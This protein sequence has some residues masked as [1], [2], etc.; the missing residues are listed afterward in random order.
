MAQKKIT[1]KNKNKKD[2]LDPGNDEFI[3]KSMSI[4]D[5]VVDRRKQIGAL[6]VVALLA[7]VAGIVINNVKEASA[8]EATASLVK[9]L[10][11]ETAPVIEL[12]EG[13]EVPPQLE[14]DFLYFDSREARGTD[15]EKAF[16]ETVAG[17]E[18]TVAGEL[19]VLGQA[20]AKMDLGKYDEA[21]KLYEEFLAGMSEG[22][23]FARWAAMEGLALAYEGAGQNEKARDKFKEL[24]GV[25]EGR[26]SLMAKYNHAR[27][28][29]V[30]GDRN[31]AGA[32]YAQLMKE[33]KADGR[34]DR[35]DYMF[36]QAREALLQINPSAPVP[37]V[38][39][40]GFGG[41]DPQI[42]QQLMRAQQ[43][44]GAGLN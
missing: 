13:D 8:A 12:P 1:V 39:G 20:S 3:V 15:A 2:D 23:S 9:G 42:L 37:E 38:P 22:A 11:A 29:E 16:A 27:M 18:G 6:L 43:G 4:L 26:L 35:L 14:D 34:I 41:M 31:R 33:I 24:A 25:A 5:W 17:Y 10:D 28:E 19:A 44:A 21:A 30:L 40:M 7:A 36:V 32:I